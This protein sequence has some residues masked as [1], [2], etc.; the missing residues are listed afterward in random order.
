[1]ILHNAEVNFFSY[2]DASALVVKSLTGNV[3]LGAD[4]TVITNMYNFI[5]QKYLAQ[6]YPASLNVSAFGGDIVLK[7]QI[8]LFPSATANLNLLAEQ[9]ITSTIGIAFGMSDGDNSLLPNAYTPVAS[10]DANLLLNRIFPFS[11]SQLNHATLPLHTG[12]KEPARVVTR[13]GDIENI[14]FNLAKKSIVTAG[15]DIKNLTLAV[16]NIDKTDVSIL[17]AGR[18][19]TYTSGRNPTTG[20]LMTNA[21]KAEYSGPGEVFVKAGRN[22]DLGASGGLSTVGNVYNSNLE[23]KGSNLTIMAGVNGQ[24]NYAGFINTYFKEGKYGEAFAKANTLIIGFM[25]ER[26]NEPLLSETKAFD[27]F[28]KLKE[29]DYVAIQPQ[30][31]SLV[32]PVFFNEIRESGSASAGTK[33]LANARGFAAIE[34]LFPGSNWKGD[35]SLFFSKIQTVDGGDINLLVPGGLVNAG[36]AVSF[37]GAKPASELGIVAQRDGNINVMA[38]DDFLVNTSRVFALDGGDIQ[39]WSSA[40]NIDAGRGAKSAI[41]AP[42]PKISFDKNGNLAIEFPPIV[43]GSGIRT[44]ASSTGVEPGDVFLFA[45]KGVVDAGEAGIGGKNVTISATAVLGA[46]NIQVSGVGSGVPV[47]STGSVAAG[48][49]GTSN[50]NANVN[51][52]AQATTGLNDNDA[53]NKKNLALGMLSVE[54][55]GFGN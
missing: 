33:A 30:L 47:A 52:V 18:D 15:R 55:L 26:L 10:G 53:E 41:A 9:N 20:G 8:V 45:P 38:H 21:A 1:M 22:V 29:A 51:Q 44:A 37:T 11:S 42:P 24:V 7:D 50:M 35:V 6:I 54:V 5:D 17:E 25:R 49:T 48:L 3:N 27:A 34:S 13:S 14:S 19:V 23:S 43:S 32:L 31:S 2:T 12:D 39:I 16:Q 36:L 46:N 28:S 40:G 4:A